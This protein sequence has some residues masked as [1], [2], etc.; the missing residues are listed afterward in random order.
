MT[1]P[2]VNAIDPIHRIFKKPNISF[3][4]LFDIKYNKSIII[5]VYMGK[6][7]HPSQGGDI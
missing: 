4:I 2:P 3:D 6:R 5:I 1:H 7:Q